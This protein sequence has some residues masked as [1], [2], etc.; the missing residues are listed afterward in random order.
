MTCQIKTWRRCHKTLFFL[1]QSQ[2]TALSWKAT[3]IKIWQKGKFC[4]ILH[5]WEIS[6][7]SLR[8]RINQE[9]RS[10]NWGALQSLKLPSVKMM[11]PCQISTWS[12]RKTLM[13]I[14]K[15]WRKMQSN[16]PISLSKMPKS[17]SQVPVK[18]PI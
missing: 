18:P 5:F 2:D 3:E 10:Q 1:N 12:V 16:W 14:Q 15:I 4:W 13:V 9:S 7:F 8:L 6:L 17:I 11:Y